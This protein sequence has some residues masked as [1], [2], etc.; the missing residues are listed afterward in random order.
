[1]SAWIPVKETH[2]RIV[3]V[4]GHTQMLNNVTEFNNTGSWL[5]LKSDEGYVIVNPENVF[6]MI[7]KGEV[8]V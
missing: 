3:S 4:N 2:R 8:V 7:V 6:L 1:M 5:R